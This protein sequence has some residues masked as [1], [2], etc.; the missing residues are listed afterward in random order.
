MIHAPHPA[1]FLE[2]RILNQGYMT[3]IG[4]ARRM[5][6]SCNLA[7]NLAGIQLQSTDYWSK[8]VDNVF[9]DED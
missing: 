3:S 8:L 2:D 6:E 9:D 5:D 1:T 4:Y 7:A